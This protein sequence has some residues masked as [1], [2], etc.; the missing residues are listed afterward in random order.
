MHV[1]VCLI[2]L[3][4]VGLITPGTAS[5]SMASMSPQQLQRLADAPWY[6]GPKFG[7]SA[8]E[9]SSRIAAAAAADPG[10]VAWLNASVASVGGDKLP[11]SVE[12]RELLGVRIT[13]GAPSAQVMRPTIVV[14]GGMHAREWVS[15]EAAVG[16]IVSLPRLARTNARMRYLLTRVAIVVLPLINPD[17]YERSVTSDRY[18]RKNMASAAPVDL[19]RNFATAWSAAGNGASDGGVDSDTY[20]GPYPFSEPESRFVRDVCLALDSGGNTISFA[21]ALHSYGQ[22]I[23]YPP[24]WQVNATSATTQLMKDM[25]SFITRKA[26]ARS[27]PAVY[28]PGDELKFLA[29]TEEFR[30]SP[31][32]NMTPREQ[33]ALQQRV[34]RMLIAERSVEYEVAPAWALYPASG[35][36]IDWIHA[37]FAAVPAATMEMRP[38]DVDCCGFTLP[39]EGINATVMD[40]I[41]FVGGAAAVVVA[42]EDRH[43]GAPARR[44]WSL[45]DSFATDL[46]SRLLFGTAVT[47]LDYVT[48]CPFAGTD[49][50]LNLAN[51]TVYS[52]PAKQLP[53]CPSF[54]DVT[55]EQGGYIGVT[56]IN[57]SLLY[58][59]L[60]N[61]SV[62]QL[63][64]CDLSGHNPAHVILNK[65]FMRIRQL[66]LAATGAAPISAEAPLAID[67]CRAPWERGPQEPDG[68]LSNLTPSHS[69]EYAPVVW[70]SVTRAWAVAGASW[71]S[72]FADDSTPVRAV[73]VPVDVE[74]LC[75]SSNV[76]PATHSCGSEGRRIFAS[77]GGFQ[78]RSVDP[79]SRLLFGLDPVARAVSFRDVMEDDRNNITA[80][81][82]DVERLD[83]EILRGNSSIIDGRAS[84]IIRVRIAAFDAVRPHAS[85]DAL[86]LTLSRLSATTALRTIGD[87]NAWRQCGLDDAMDDST[88]RVIR[89]APSHPEVAATISWARSGILKWGWLKQ[90]VA[91]LY[92]RFVIAVLLA[93]GFL[94]IRLTF[95]PP[96]SQLSIPR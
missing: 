38:A 35:D 10:F 50:Y 70:N 71:F 39:S 47:A 14:L 90:H 17:G 52:S 53:P 60:L 44:W 87:A 7:R 31:I 77:L 29:A 55:D 56:R 46:E 41:A 74:I 93:W 63:Q 75:P 91:L 67:R 25:L 12:G 62:E 92:M 48:L 22:N 51:G 20:G 80:A 43:G 79:I 28:H 34:K 37:T 58:Q 3:S 26:L 11:R 84:V 33:T 95:H 36:A 5:A 2:V 61:Q 4:I 81:V 54:G 40:A 66:R 57:A 94:Y 24:G 89:I 85:L 21:L 96:I 72:H 73:S 19:N 65:N 49:R 23:Q 59:Q 76:T 42:A 16:L 8:A 78:T 69:V 30:P 68:S 82:W 6:H 88:Y 13:A 9:Q 83:A 18:W 27:M 86:D 15:V 1:L 32:L 45:V 64:S